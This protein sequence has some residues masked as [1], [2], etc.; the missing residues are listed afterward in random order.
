MNRLVYTCV[1]K[2][3]SSIK[4][5][6]FQEAEQIKVKGGFYKVMYEAIEN[7]FKV[8]ANRYEKLKGKF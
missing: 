1:A 3:G 7:P 2:D 5:N 6:T 4:V 8:A